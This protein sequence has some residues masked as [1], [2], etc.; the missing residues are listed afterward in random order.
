MN[1]NSLD[2]VIQDSNNA[3]EL[4]R[5][6]FD[7]MFMEINQMQKQLADDWISMSPEDRKSWVLSIPD[8]ELHNFFSSI[9]EGLGWSAPSLTDAEIKKLLK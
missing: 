8:E 1:N 5:K 2:Q 7:Q 4:L 6:A 9:F 3:P